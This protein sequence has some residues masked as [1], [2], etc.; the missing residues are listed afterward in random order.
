MGG[1]LA[2]GGPSSGG[3]GV[4]HDNDSDDTYMTPEADSTYSCTRLKI[5]FISTKRQVVSEILSKER[6]LMGN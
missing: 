2:V 5:K 4:L 3:G 1:S 6:H